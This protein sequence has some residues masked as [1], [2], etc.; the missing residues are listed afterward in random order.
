MIVTT[1]SPVISTLY[2]AR[3][4]FAILGGRTLSDL[5]GSTSETAVSA[6]RRKRIGSRSPV[7]LQIPIIPEL[8]NIIDVTPCG[9]LAFLVTEF[10]RPFSSAGF[11][12]KFRQ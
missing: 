3:T 6:L 9:D 7:S 1:G 11:G 8:H 12:N 2:L 10:G 5:G 4:A